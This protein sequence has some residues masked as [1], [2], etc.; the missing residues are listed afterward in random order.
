LTG[1]DN[2]VPDHRVMAETWK[3]VA[4]DSERAGLGWRERDHLLEAGE[5]RDIGRL[6]RKPCWSSDE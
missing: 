2:V 4:Y 1:L 5:W 6:R 3:L